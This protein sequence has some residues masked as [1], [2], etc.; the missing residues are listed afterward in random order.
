MHNNII[1]LHSQY[2]SKPNTSKRSITVICSGEGHVCSALLE[3]FL[4]QLFLCVRG[5][6]GIQPLNRRPRTV[7]TCAIS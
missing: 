1:Y 6:L 2:Y 5:I 7:G 4:A 3:Y